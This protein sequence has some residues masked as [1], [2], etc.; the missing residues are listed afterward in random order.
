MIQN[1]D[2]S[3]NSTN[4]QPKHNSSS[5]V[6]NGSLG[7]EYL[8]AAYMNKVNTHYKLIKPIVFIAL[9]LGILLGFAN[10]LL[11]DKSFLQDA[12]SIIHQMQMILL[13]TL[14]DGNVK[15]YVIDLIIECSFSALSIFLFPEKM[16]KSM[17]LIK[18]L[19]SIEPDQ[20]LL[21]LGV[22]T[23]STIVSCI[24]LLIILIA[25]AIIH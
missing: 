24:L 13:L 25:L 4:G 16:L 11:F 10:G 6:H 21:D 1:D 23:G 3:S 19:Y 12:W 2:A 18:Q 9:S 14:I 20:Y 5:T 15:F 22:T 17:P 7:D 8:S